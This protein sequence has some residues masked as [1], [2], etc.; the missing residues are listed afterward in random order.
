MTSRASPTRTI[1]RQRLVLPCRLLLDPRRSLFCVFTDTCIH[2][3]SQSVI[4]KCSLIYVVLASDR[5]AMAH[6]VVVVGWCHPVL[7]P[8]SHIHRCR[9]PLCHLR[10]RYG[11]AMVGCTRKRLCVESKQ[12]LLPSPMSL[13]FRFRALLQ[14]YRS[15]SC[16]KLVDTSPPQHHSVSVQLFTTIELLALPGESGRPRDVTLL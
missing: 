9:S 2:R 1:D 8:A 4:Y 14:A 10:S 5:A 7:R 13:I 3:R 16:L 6:R 15:D 11:Q 12:G